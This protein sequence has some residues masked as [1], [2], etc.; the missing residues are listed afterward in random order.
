MTDTFLFFQNG[1]VIWHPNNSFWN[2]MRLRFGLSVDPF[3]AVEL[4]EQLK[5]STPEKSTEL[6]REISQK[7]TEERVKQMHE[8]IRRLVNISHENGN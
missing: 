5:A 2:R 3:R 7:A 1:I 6:E 8:A 4:A